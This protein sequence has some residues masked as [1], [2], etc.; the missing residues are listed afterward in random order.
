M[1]RDSMT[2]KEQA[3][4]TREQIISAALELFAERGFAATS[5]RRVAEAAGVSEGLIF[6]H[7][8]NKQAL[9]VAVARSRST[10]SR[11]ISRLADQG[12][13]LPA[14]TCLSMIGTRFVE[15]L[16]V[17]GADAQMVAMMVGE[18]QTNPTLHEVF[19]DVVESASSS[20][21]AYFQ[22]RIEAGELREDLL[23]QTS[24]TA[25]IGSLMLFFMTHSHLES[26]EW[27]R[28]ASAH[29][30]ASVE[31]WLRGALRESQEEA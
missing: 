11:E 7:F 9:L 15:M 10:F 12:A 31:L 25:F 22:A 24:A 30:E 1:A 19:R 6:H 27:S 18:A 4:Q 14:R 5:T 20:L 29:V 13:R 2:R 8:P 17:G 3:E 21:A 28:L 26:D 23:A 16:D